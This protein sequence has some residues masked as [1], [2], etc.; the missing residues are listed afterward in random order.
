MNVR[1]I[2]SKK[3]NKLPLNDETRYTATDYDICYKV[4]R[5]YCCCIT[6]GEIN[7]IIVW[8]PIY[9]VGNIKSMLKFVDILY[10]QYNISYIRVEGR[11]GRYIF[12]KR[13]FGSNM[14]Y[15]PLQNNRDAYWCCINHDIIKKI[16][17]LL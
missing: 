3:W 5:L 2:S 10:S 15:Q 4:G 9:D 1:K 11:H 16:N 7:N 13:L 14:L 12:F 17:E 6:N 8:S